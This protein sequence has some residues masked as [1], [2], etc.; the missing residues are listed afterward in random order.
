MNKCKPT[1]LS[2][3]TCVCVCE[4]LCKTFSISVM[5]QDE[6]TQSESVSA[7]GVENRGKLTIERRKL[8]IEKRHNSYFMFE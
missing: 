8:D 3:V 1:I 2:V 6:S 4:C 7:K 5:E